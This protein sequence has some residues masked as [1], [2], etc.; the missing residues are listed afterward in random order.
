[1]RGFWVKEEN[2]HDDV[3]REKLDA[4]KPVA[5]VVAAYVLRDPVAIATIFRQRKF[6]SHLAANA[7]EAK[8]TIG[9]TRSS[10]SLLQAGT[11][12][13]GLRVSF[14]PRVIPHFPARNRY[15]KDQNLCP[16]RP[17]ASDSI[18]MF[19]MNVGDRERRRAPQ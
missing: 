4:F 11:I 18:M 14:G 13:Y 17:L 3:N 2:R 6:G 19:P 1:M 12:S 9:V 10:D 7:C 16:A 15:G 8:T 5:F